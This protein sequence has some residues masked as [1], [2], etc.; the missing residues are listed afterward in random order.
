MSYLSE[1][2]ALTA[3][4]EIQ[5]AIRLTAAIFCGAI[6]GWEREAKNRPAG[7]RTHIRGCLAA[8]TFTVVTL[9]LA[10]WGLAR[11]LKGDPIRAIEA[12]TAGVAFLA[13]GTII[14]SRGQVTGLTTGASLWLVGA[15]GVSA[16]TG[17]YTLAIMVTMLA[18]AVLTWLQW[19]SQRI[20]EQS[21][22]AET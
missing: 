20:T 15:I 1:L 5:V 4:D 14:Q 16:G 2:F 9:E 22:D 13:A 18:L 10:E 19:L 7:L 8:C 12:V 3:M 21:K 11:G 17:M 6:I